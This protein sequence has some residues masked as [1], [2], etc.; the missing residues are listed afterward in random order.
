SIQHGAFLTLL[1]LVTLAFLGLLVGFLQPIFWA[2]VL[3]VLFYPF[4][5]RLTRALRGRSG[6]AALVSLLVIL[7]SVILPLFAIGAAVTNEAVGLY[8]RLAAGEFDLQEPIRR[9][10]EAL[11]VVAGYLDQ[12]GV[13][14]ERVKAGLSDAAL[15]VSQAAANRAVELGQGTVTFAILF[16]LMLYLLFFFLKDAD[17]LTA[18]LIRALPLGDD[19]ERRLFRK[20]ADVSRATIKGTV[21]VGIVQGAIGGVLFW[22][23]GL[24]APVLWGVVMALASLL[25]AVGPA[26]VWVPAAILLAAAGN[27]V[28]AG[29]VVAVGVLIIGMADN[30]L[31]P[32]LVGR[33]TQM[34]D[35]LILLSTLGG[36]AVFGLSGVVVGPVIAALFL[37]VWEMFVEEYG[38]A[39]DAQAPP[40]S[41]PPSAPPRSGPS[42]D[43]PIPPSTPRPPTDPPPSDASPSEPTPAP[44]ASR[45]IQAQQP[46]T[47]QPHT[48]QPQT[49]RPRTQPP[50]PYAPVA[51]PSPGQTRGTT[52]PFTATPA[53]LP[54]RRPRS[55][56]ATIRPVPLSDPLP[57]S[58]RRSPPAS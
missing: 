48:Q 35:Y 36:L 40:S 23:L 22:A 46:Y 11:P 2:A 54:P 8:N 18:G 26:L 51:V 38:D 12:L 6:I 7:L 53:E 4:Q 5:W 13:D 47:Q 17:R 42:T 41:T 57:T 19:R 33:D 34:P 3:A 27:Y 15:T 43:A 29:I 44:V 9:F 37:A 52:L 49:P 45:P 56:T 30:V 21:V 10:E 31:R 32:I 55:D 24:P 50:S 20:F 28:D 16:A 1:V 39:D 58:P 14:F 25:P